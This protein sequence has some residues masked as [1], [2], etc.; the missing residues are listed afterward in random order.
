MIA[1]V[2]LKTLDTIC[3]QSNWEIETKTISEFN[4]ICEKAGLHTLI[5]YVE[6]VLADTLDRELLLE[7]TMFFLSSYSFLFKDA[8]FRTN[9]ISLAEK[10]SAADLTITEKNNL[11]SQIAARHV[12]FNF[13]IAMT[14]VFDS[15]FMAQETIG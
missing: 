10:L 13:H 8:V 9:R 2:Y 6:D 7:F 11:L 12:V 3:F 14:E 15:L 4:G 5:Q 1:H